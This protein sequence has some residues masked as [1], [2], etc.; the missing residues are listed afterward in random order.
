MSLWCALHNSQRK[1][2][3]DMKG[4]KTV[5]VLGAL[6]SASYTHDVSTAASKG[7]LPWK[8]RTG[9]KLTVR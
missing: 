2:E 7:R 3:F 8:K 6:F 4:L 5:K 9:F 1:K